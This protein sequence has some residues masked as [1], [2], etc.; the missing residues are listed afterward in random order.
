MTNN[1]QSIE[2]L[3][4]VLPILMKATQQHFLHA[5]IN[6]KKGYVKLGKRM[7]EEFQEETETAGKIAERIL[8][9]GGKVRLVNADV[10]LHIY[11]NIEEQLRKECEFQFMSVDLLEKAIRGSELDLVTET[12]MTDYLANE[13]NHAAWLKQQVDLIDEIGIQNYLSK[14]M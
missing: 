8:E 14:Q 6:M 5:T 12:F 3:Q 1:N 2:L 9:L 13:T 11:E 7:L 4:G 10:E